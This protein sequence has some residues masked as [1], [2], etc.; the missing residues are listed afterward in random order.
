MN[1]LK[2]LAFGISALA[3]TSMALTAA[4]DKNED[5]ANRLSAVGSVCLAGEC[6]QPAGTTAPIV[7]AQ[8][9][10][11]SGEDIYTT[12]CSACHNT[13]AGNA[14]K[15]GDKAAWEPRIAKG[16]DTLVMNAINGF[17]DVGMMPP[18][19]ICMDCSDDE[20]KITVEYMVDQ[21]Q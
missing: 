5:I 16:M 8:A 6:E 10:A 18:K 12:K 21:S 7:V 14:P 20:L 1:Y 9:S 13:G 3:L 11:R 19:G 2:K 4:A 15:M 17:T